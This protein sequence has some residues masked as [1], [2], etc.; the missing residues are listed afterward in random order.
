M[1]FVSLGTM[2]MP[3]VRM[4][5][6]VDAW[7]A[8][9]QEPVVVQAGYT[10]YTFRHARSFDFCTKD[11]MRRYIDEASILILQGGWGAIS[12]AME[13]GKHIV[14]MPR[15]EGSEHIHDQ[16]QLVRKLDALGCVV[17]VFDEA[18]LAR[19]VEEARTFNF[20][21]LPYGNAESLI[22]AKLREWFPRAE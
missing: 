22:E 21:R 15:H 12:E 1:I 20:Q 9:T 3:F 18:Q 16:E 7:A 6:A 4:A 10:K 13:L 19:K 2:D 5:A 17:G 11:E 8:T 14:V